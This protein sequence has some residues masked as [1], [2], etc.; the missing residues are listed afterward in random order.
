MSSS[1]KHVEPRYEN[2]VAA[3]KGGMGALSFSCV[4]GETERMLPRSAFRGVSGRT[5]WV[6]QRKVDLHLQAG[7]GW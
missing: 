6:R 7:L 2:F 1:D 5:Q 3:K 4:P